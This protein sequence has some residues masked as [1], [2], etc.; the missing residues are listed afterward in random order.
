[1]KDHKPRQRGKQQVNVIHDHSRPRQKTPNT[2]TTPNKRH[3]GHPR[4]KVRN[5]L[6]PQRQGYVPSVASSATTNGRDISR[7]YTE[8]PWSSVGG[9]PR[10]TRMYITGVGT[11]RPPLGSRGQL[12]IHIDG[13]RDR[14]D[15]I[16]T[17]THRI[18]AREQLKQGERAVP[19]RGCRRISE[20]RNTVI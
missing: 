11:N 5:Q 3:P 19:R 2:R 10:N 6:S 4:R 17:T 9:A 16:G 12:P 8:T 13:Q 14:L 15:P 7:R 20:K 18:Q 1:M